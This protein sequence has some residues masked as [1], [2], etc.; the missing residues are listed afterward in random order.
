MRMDCSCDGYHCGAASRSP[1]HLTVMCLY[2]RKRGERTPCALLFA[3]GG[4]SPQCGSALRLVPHPA[5]TTANRASSLSLLPR[6]RAADSAVLR[7]VLKMAHMGSEAATHMVPL[8]V[9]GPRG[10]G[11][12]THTPHGERGTV[13]CEATHDVILFV[14]LPR[15]INVE[16]QCCALIAMA[17]FSVGEE[18]L[19]DEVLIEHRLN[20]GLRMWTWTHVSGFM[21]TLHHLSLVEVGR[22]CRRNASDRVPLKG[23]RR[24]SRKP[25]T[26]HVV[27]P[28]Q[29]GQPEGEQHAFGTRNK[30]SP[31]IPVV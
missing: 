24:K 19:T 10:D 3:G 22:D 14:W 31:I 17:T 4:G 29:S 1:S 27:V 2:A 9:N 7:L 20:P 15:H 11:E 28:L 8:A 23:A 18:A 30:T 25:K 5:C 6:I 21:R 13:R 12:K 16:K 26:L